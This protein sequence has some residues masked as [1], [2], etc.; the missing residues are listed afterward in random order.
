VVV[1]PGPA[2]PEAISKASPIWAAPETVES[3]DCNEPDVQWNC[4]SEPALPETVADE[5]VNAPE[6]KTVL[7]AAPDTVED[8]A[9]NDPDARLEEVPH[10]PDPQ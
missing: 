2:T 6:A 3:A 9:C 1:F 4:F 8:S 5:D 10:Q 7:V